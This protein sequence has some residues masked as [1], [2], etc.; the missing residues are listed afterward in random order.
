MELP[1]GPWE[2]VAIDIVGPFESATWDCRYSITLVDYYSKWPEVAFASQVSSD[3]II[4]FLDTIFS[5]EGTP[6]CLVSDNGP[7]LTST[8][9]ADFL[10]EHNIQHLYSSVYYPQANGAVE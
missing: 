3:V 8:A 1:N 2:K 7:Q 6:L 9:F 5:R 10:K 4:N